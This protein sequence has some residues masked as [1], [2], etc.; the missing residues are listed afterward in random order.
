MAEEKNIDFCE[1]RKLVY[2]IT[3]LNESAIVVLEKVNAMESDKV[4]TILKC[5]E[6]KINFLLEKLEDL[7]AKR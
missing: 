2:E 7:G 5:N 3:N 4:I 6:E 1:L